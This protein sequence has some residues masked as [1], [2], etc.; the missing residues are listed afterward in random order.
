MDETVPTRTPAK[1]VL[2]KLASSPVPLKAISLFV[3][4][5]IARMLFLQMVGFD[6]AGWYVDS[7]HHWQI[8]FYTLHIGLAQNPPRMWDLSGQEYFWG[9]LP[10][11][12]ESLLLYLFNSTTLT[13]FRVFNSVVGSIS[14]IF[15]YFIG[16]R[17]FS[18]GVGIVAGIA[19]AL[20][21]VLWEADTSGMLDPLGLTLLLL[22]ILLYKRKNYTCGVVLGLASLAH[23]D[24][25][26]LSLALISFYLMFEGSFTGFVSALLGWLT[27]MVPYFYFM[28]SATGEA[29]Y[30]LH[31]NFLSNIG[32]AGIQGI[33]VPFQDQILARSVFIVLLL[34]AVV[35][36]AR[37]IRQKPSSYPA[38]GFFLSRVAMHGV[39]FGLTPYVIPYIFFGQI[40]RV[41]IDRLFALEYYYIP[42]VVA[43]A[44]FAFYKK[45]DGKPA[46][47][48]K[49]STLN[50]KRIETTKPE[51]AT[52]IRLTGIL[53]IL[54]VFNACLVPL[55][56]YEYYTT[57]GP[58]EY[59]LQIADYITSHYV[60]G[61]IVNSLVIVNYRLINNGISYRHVL[62]TLY[63]PA[64][65]GS[66]ARDWLLKNYVTWV[67]A[68]NNLDTC[69]PALLQSSGTSPFRL[70]FGTQV[71][72]V[73][74]QQLSSET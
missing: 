66:A 55:V 10:T 15:V 53:V 51:S 38:H 28:Q 3:V 26:F 14:V 19:T 65:G 58:Y 37:L 40:P 47:F 5:I 68:D 31:Y 60:G 13:P 22:A 44:V 70:V 25:W 69:F 67:I 9:P 7:Y 32:G 74:Q 56:T 48:F 17:Y 2:S 27:P 43:V 72:S 4:A 71:Y 49:R 24:F 42:F 54:L 52:R 63:C 20:S 61:T 18:D 59:Q 50:K 73:D 35:Y 16:R 8:A 62:G 39:I 6:Y 30:A 23:I 21:P 34:I 57:Y 12:A 36:G 46:F 64:G 45:M 1:S 33:T 29:L 41:L 11:L